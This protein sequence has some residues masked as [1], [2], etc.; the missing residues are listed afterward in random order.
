MKTLLSR[1][2]IFVC[3]VPALRITKS[4]WPSPLK[5]ATAA[6]AAPGVA[7][8]V[9]VGVGLGVDVGAGV[10]VGYAFTTVTMPVIPKE[11]CTTQK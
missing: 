9:E 3:R 2:Q 1:Y 6:V 5:S 7:L 4:G 11:Q 8:G 10:G